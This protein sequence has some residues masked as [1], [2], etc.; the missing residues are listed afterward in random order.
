MLFQPDTARQ[1]YSKAHLHPDEEKFFVPGQPSSG[2]IGNS[3]C[4]ALAI[5]YELSVPEHAANARRNGADIYIASVAKSVDQIDGALERLSE[6]AR[7]YSMTV[8][9]A[10]C[11]GLS[12]SMECAGR[13]SVWNKD[14]TLLNQI[15]VAKEG[16]VVVDTET[17]CVSQ[18]II[19]KV[20]LLYDGR[21]HPTP[22]FGQFPATP[23]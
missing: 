18:R 5:C 14:G 2:L 10:N 13:T 21:G 9:M 19:E 7:K 23:G 12:D 1:L 15:D 3:P 16:I 11:I 6:I 20:F 4:A 22:I 8:A 17:H